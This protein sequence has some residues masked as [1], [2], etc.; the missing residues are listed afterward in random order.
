MRYS[1]YRMRRTGQACGNGWGNGTARNASGFERTVPALVERR[2]TIV[3][4]WKVEE[5][6]RAIMKLKAV[7][8][9]YVVSDVHRRLME[10]LRV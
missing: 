10:G 4:R 7:G 2:R 9:L 5:D 3:L 6:V 1:L 8:R